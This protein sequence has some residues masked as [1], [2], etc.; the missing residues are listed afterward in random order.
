MATDSHT[1]DIH[2]ITVE[3]IRKSVK[4]MRLTVVPPDGLV[5]VSV[6]KRIDDRT[7]RTAVTNKLDWIREK[8]RLVVERARHEARFH[9]E[10]AS[11]ET[12]WSWGRPYRLIVVEGSGR[13]SVSVRD[14]DQMVMRVPSGASAALRLRVLDGW[15]RASLA[16]RIPGLIETW[17]PVV[18]EAVAEWRIKKMK[19]RWGSCNPRARRVWLALELAKR[20]PECTEY[21]L[22]H[23]MVHLIEPSHNRRFYRIMDR[24]LPDWRARRDELNRVPGSAGGE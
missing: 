3:V 4:H 16:S 13:P 10:V 20:G 8:Q 9:R 15:Y 12:H 24:L 2:E 22:V 5:R 7:V 19:T 18:G 23:E 11:G 17:E 14:G 21:V 6:P 1:I